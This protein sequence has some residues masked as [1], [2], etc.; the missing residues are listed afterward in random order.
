MVPGHSLPGICT[1]LVLPTVAS[2]ASPILTGRMGMGR[3][4][5]A[6]TGQVL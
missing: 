6:P 5:K 3:R 4:T 1:T 2:A